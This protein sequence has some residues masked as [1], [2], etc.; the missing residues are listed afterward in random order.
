MNI[1]RLTI[2]LPWIDSRLMPN[3][4][5]G[6]AWQSSHAAK[7]KARQD[8]TL[9]AR[10]ALGRNTLTP[11]ETYPLNIL[12][13]AP[14]GRHGDLDNMLAASKA[15]LDGVADALGIN[16]KCF[17]PITINVARDSKKQGFVIV[18]VGQ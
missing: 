1:D 15:A 5:N 12:Y 2:T 3:R 6:S 16:D 17:R 18:E 10:A 8:G 9:S 14:D 13:V 11:A 7:I 4:K